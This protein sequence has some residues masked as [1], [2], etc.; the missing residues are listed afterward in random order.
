MPFLPSLHPFRLP[1][2]IGKFWGDYLKEK[3]MHVSRLVWLDVRGEKNQFKE[4][5]EVECVS[6]FVKATNLK[7]IE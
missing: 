1:G 3:A 7:K 4:K 6:E 5:E 2:D